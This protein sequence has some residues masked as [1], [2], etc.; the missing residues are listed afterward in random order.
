MTFSLQHLVTFQLQTYLS[1]ESFCEWKP[2]HPFAITTALLQNL[3]SSAACSFTINSHPHEQ[4]WPPSTRC[5]QAS[6][7]CLPGKDFF[8]HK[9]RERTGQSQSHLYSPVPLLGKCSGVCS[10]LHLCLDHSARPNSASTNKQDRSMQRSHSIHQALSCILT[11][12]QI[13]LHK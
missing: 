1:A 2:S 8:F 6:N 13:R 3:S 10:R 4:S 12:F 7:V 11:Q 9:T 5:E